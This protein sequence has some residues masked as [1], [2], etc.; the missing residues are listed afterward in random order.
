MTLS[1]AL[2]S[3]SDLLSSS[4]VPSWPAVAVQLSLFNASAKPPAL[5]SLFLLSSVTSA[6]LPFGLAVSA[7]S[8]TVSVVVS[9]VIFLLSNFKPSPT[10]ALYLTVTPSA[11]VLVTVALVPSPSAKVTFVPD[12]TVSNL[13]S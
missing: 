8:F 4:P 7:P 5:T 6:T 1:P 10:F 3:C 13:P 2:T 9:A 12:V 11:S